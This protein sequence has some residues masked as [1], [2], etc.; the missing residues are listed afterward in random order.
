MRLKRDARILKTKAVH[1]LR[2]AMQTFNA[3]SEEGR[4]DSVLLHLQHACE[5][6]LKAV[7]L[8][9]KHKV[10]DTKSGRS[11]GFD[12]CLN[13]CSAS[14][15]LRPTEAGIM[16]TVDA[17]RDEAQHW[18]VVVEE[19]L[20]YL[21]TRAV[22][23]AFDDY[24]KRK[25]GDDLRAHIPPRVLPVSTLPPG[26]FEYLVDRE[27]KAIKEL[28]KPG[29][30]QRDEARGRIRALLSMEALV[31]EDVS[32]TKHD[33]DRIE[34]AIKEGKKIGA[35]FPRLSTVDTT[36]TGEGATVTVRFTKKEGAPVRFV[37]GDDTTEA[38]AIREVDLLKKFHLSASDLAHKI[39]LT[40]N[41]SFALR[42][43]L[44]VDTDPTCAHEF[45]F[46]RKQRHLCFSDNAV[47]RMK[48]ALDGG[49]DMAVVW[50]EHRAGLKGVG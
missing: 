13:L 20:L 8:Q 37:S 35:V 9:S 42:C 7:L 19:D 24:L 3:Y 36:M 22:V 27:F 33:V 39:K 48:E 50:A 5:M 23:T 25:L 12:K 1:S 6:L 16:R 29:N 4:M 10:F 26:D 2:I 15:G 32:V 47:R 46:S 18:F 28:L 41:K 17:L 43:R 44:G 49:L 40:N 38:G 45:V 34:D 21:H 31:K 14:H 30:R 11:I